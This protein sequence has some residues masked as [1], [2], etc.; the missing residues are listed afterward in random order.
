MFNAI[1]LAICGF[2]AVAGAIKLFSET[3]SLTL[4]LAIALPIYAFVLSFVARRRE[5]PH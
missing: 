5:R 1:V 4:T 3:E 2:F